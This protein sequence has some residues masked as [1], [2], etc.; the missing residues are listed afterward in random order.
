MTMPELK[1]AADVL[2]ELAAAT[3][4]RAFLP[5]GKRKLLR[6]DSGRTGGDVRSHR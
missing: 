2:T 4:D 6:V 5:G 1:T 3:P